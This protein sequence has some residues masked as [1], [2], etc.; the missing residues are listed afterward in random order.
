[1]NKKGQSII[2]LVIQSLVVVIVLIAALEYFN[3]TQFNVVEF[4]L[5]AAKSVRE[6]MG[7]LAADLKDQFVSFGLFKS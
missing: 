2:S 6:V 7:K 1:M 3:I 4:I 5:S